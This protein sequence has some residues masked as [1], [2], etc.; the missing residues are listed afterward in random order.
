MV[1]FTK[2]KTTGRADLEDMG[3]KTSF[4]NTLS[5]IDLLDMQIEMSIEQ[6]QVQVWNSGD[7]P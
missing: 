3:Q 5:Q 7:W 1:P 6:I 2:E 4:M